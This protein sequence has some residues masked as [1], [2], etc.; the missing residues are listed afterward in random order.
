MFL[1]RS[2][3]FITLW[4]VYRVVVC[5][6]VCLSRCGMFIAMQ[7]VYGCRGLIALWWVY[8]MVAGLS[9]S[10]WFIM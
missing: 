6:V 10:R 5:L 9:R 1:S 7:F 3:V 2:G 8:S 4:Y